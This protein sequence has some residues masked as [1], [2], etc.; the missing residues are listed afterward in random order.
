MRVCNNFDPRS[1]EGKV[2]NF[3]PVCIF[4]F[5]EKHWKFFLYT[6][7]AFYLMMC[8]DFDPGSFEQVQGHWKER[9]NKELIICVRSI[10]FLW[11]NIGLSFFTLKLHLTWGYVMI[12]TQ[13]HSDKF[14]VTGRRSA[15]IY[16]QSL[17]FLWR[18]IESS[19]FTKQLLIIW[20]WSW[21]WPKVILASSRSWE[22]K[23]HFFV[24]SKPF[25]WRKKNNPTSHNKIVWDL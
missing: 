25:L 5:M 22:R 10:S 23:V 3:R 9:V 13:V 18:N 12:L 4:F 8:N 17:S 7:I 15:K 1:L 21:F 6:K 14:K 19:Y 24:R 2:Q 16:V 20:G 11:R